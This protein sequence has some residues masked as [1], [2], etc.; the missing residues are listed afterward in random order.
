MADD[1]EREPGRLLLRGAS[2]MVTV[3][4]AA[5]YIVLGGALLLVRT[6]AD[7]LGLRRG[8]RPRASLRVGRHAPLG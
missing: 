7:L 4:V 6:M 3:P 1:D 8:H 5:G 2:L